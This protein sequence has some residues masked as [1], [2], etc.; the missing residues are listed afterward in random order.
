VVIGGG[1]TGVEIAGALAELAH[2]I[3]GRDFRNLS[4]TRPRILLLQGSDRVLPTFAPSLSTQARKTLERKGVEVRTN[5]LAQAI[6]AFG[7]QIDGEK[8]LTT[9]VI[10]AA[11]VK[12][13]AIGKTLGMPLDQEGRVIVGSDL[14]LP[15]Y[16]ETF[17]IGDQVHF[18]TPSGPLPGLAPVAMQQ[19]VHAAKNILQDL[20]H[21]PRKPFRYL[22]KG[23]MAVIGRNFAVSD[24]HGLRT[25]GWFAWLM[26]L[27]VHILYLVGHRN[28][29]IVLIN[30]AWSY[31][32]FKRGMRLITN[33][34]WKEVEPAPAD[35]TLD[36]QKRNS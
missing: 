30:W 9:Q 27:F 25:G 16:P 1:P 12:P 7:V 13:A 3:A 31:L 5:Q 6:D 32:T 10:W 2:T 4:S 17:V 18:E 20:D 26:W 28:R 8:I 36:L 11:G 24:F 34:S 22:D 23:A 35:S 29:L 14:S 21:K 19:G 33:S 15:G